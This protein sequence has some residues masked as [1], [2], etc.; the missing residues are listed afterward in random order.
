MMAL[1]F[2]FNDANRL[3]DLYL[4]DPVKA[5]I[6]LFVFLGGTALVALIWAF[7]WRRRR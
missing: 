5:A 7:L 4:Q 2:S 6:C 3:Y 1:R